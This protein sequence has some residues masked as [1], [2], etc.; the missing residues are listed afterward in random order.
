VSKRDET[1]KTVRNGQK[2]GRGTPRPTVKRVEDSPAQ[3][4]LI[5]PKGVKLTKT[6]G[7]GREKERMCTVLRGSKG[8]GRS[9]GL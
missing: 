4:R 8:T 2:L 9:P 5:S 6:D 1:V 3:G 7:K